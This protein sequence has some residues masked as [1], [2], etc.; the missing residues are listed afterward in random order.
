MKDA[1]RSDLDEWAMYLIENA[2]HVLVMDGISSDRDLFTLDELKHFM[3]E[4]IR[5]RKP[6]NIALSK[7]LRRT[8][9]ISDGRSVRTSTG[10]KKLWAVRN[11]EGW[12]KVGAKEL[13]EHYS[14]SG[15]YKHR[16]RKKRKM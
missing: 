2:D 16:E 8:N 1:S 9:S 11:Q 15:T 6:T 10:I 3:P 4:E 13:G 12:D 7:S 5:A 14:V